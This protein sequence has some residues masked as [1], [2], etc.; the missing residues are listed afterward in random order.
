[1]EFHWS[2]P[3]LLYRTDLAEQHVFDKF[4][5]A[6]DDGGS[7]GGAT[8][9]GNH[10]ISSTSPPISSMVVGNALNNNNDGSPNHRLSGSHR[11]G[12][13]L[14]GGDN[15][16][17]MRDVSLDGDRDRN[18]DNNDKNGKG[19]SNNAYRPEATL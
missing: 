13:V 19:K 15:G 18:S 5:K 1:M 8:T 17:L 7:N 12:T 6:N 3:V 2:E 16:S 11:G 14:A 4:I 10:I 9:S